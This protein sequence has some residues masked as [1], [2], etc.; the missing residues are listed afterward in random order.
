MLLDQAYVQ[1]GN[2]EDTVK[3]TD[4]AMKTTAYRPGG[5][6]L[7]HDNR[8]NQNIGLQG[9]LITTRRWF[10]VFRAHTDFNGNFQVNGAYSRACNFSLHYESPGFN[11][12]KHFFASI[13][14]INGPK[15]NSD[16]NYTINGGYNNFAGSVF[17]GA[18][19]YHNKDISGLLTF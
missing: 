5:Q 14:Y 18:Y 8:L 9:V 15:Q 3:T 4:G 2:Y 11:V 10:T 12:R 7:I 1:T 13:A 16:W 19:Y 17:K 6:I